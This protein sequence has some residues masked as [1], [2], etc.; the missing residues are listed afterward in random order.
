M[1]S[2]A[3]N[4]PIPAT[5]APEIR[6]GTADALVAFQDLVAKNPAPIAIKY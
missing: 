3:R 2:R 6:V 5:K 4:T 1:P